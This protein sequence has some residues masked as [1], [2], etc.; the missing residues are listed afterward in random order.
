MNAPL[1][2]VSLGSPAM[3]PGTETSGANAAPLK[4]THG[5]RRN[6]SLK[7]LPS[8]V[9]FLANARHS[10]AYFHGAADRVD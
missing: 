4:M 9:S 6:V 1:V 3:S 8:A 5:K 7:R 10:G 2:P